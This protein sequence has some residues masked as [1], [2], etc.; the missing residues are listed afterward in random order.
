MMDFACINRQNQ[1][2]TVDRQSLKVSEKLYKN[3]Q[4]D[5]FQQDLEL[6][7]HNRSDSINNWKYYVTLSI[8]FPKDKHKMDSKTSQQLIMNYLTNQRLL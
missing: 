4:E 8:H 2:H 5:V 7:S 6:K 1:F 3:L